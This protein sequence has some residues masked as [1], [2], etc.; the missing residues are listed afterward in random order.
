MVT[1]FASIKKEASPKQRLK[2]GIEI[3]I[4]ASPR[5]WSSKEVIMAN[6]PKPLSQKTIE[7]SSIVSF[8]GSSNRDK[9]LA[10]FALLGSA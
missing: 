3:S 8:E 9:S 6:S 5:A 2:L 7:E 1:L 4:G 10:G